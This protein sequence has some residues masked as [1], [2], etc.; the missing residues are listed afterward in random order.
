MAPTQPGTI[1]IPTTDATPPTVMLT[2]RFAEPGKPAA[3]VTGISSD[4]TV[5]ISGNEEVTLNA[6]CTDND[7]GCKDIQIW[8]G[9]RRWGT[10]PDGTAWVSGPGLLG[11]PEASNPDRVAQRPG[12][13]AQTERVATDK[14]KISLPAAGRTKVRYE[15]WAVA[16]NFHGGQSQSKQL[17]LEAPYN[18]A[19]IQVVPFPVAPNR[20]VRVTVNATDSVTGQPLAGSIKIANRVVANTNTPFSY[21]FRQIRIRVGPGRDDWDMIYPGGI[22]MISGYPDTPVDFGLN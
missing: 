15:I 9:I 16:K 5:K 8:V 22:V 2:A 20:Q 3:S 4:A 21:T 14:I 12:D 7:G 18:T 6:V 19:R 13:R 1:A 10:N 11:A 17:M